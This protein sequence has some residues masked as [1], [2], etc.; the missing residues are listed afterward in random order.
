MRKPLIV[1]I[2]PGTTAAYCALDAKGDIVALDSGKQLNPSSIIF[3]LNQLGRVIVI[4]TDKRKTPFSVEKISI[5]LGAR[6][7]SP[8]E[9]ISVRDKF[10][11]SE[12]S[13]LRNNHELDA[14]ASARYAF[15]KIEPLLTKIKT[16]LKEEGK[17][18]LFEKIAPLVVIRGINIKTAISLIE[19]KEESIE[20]KPSA[21]YQKPET[22]PR[23]F[24][25]IINSLRKENY[26]LKKQNLR[27]LRVIE[28]KRDEKKLLL[29]KLRVFDINV[30]TQQILELQEK[31]IRKLNRLLKENEAYQKKLIGELI[32]LERIILKENSEFIIV[33]KFAS[34]EGFYQ[35]ERELELKKGDV[36]FIDSFKGMDKNKIDSLKKKVN[37]MTHKAVLPEILK[38]EN[39]IFIN[40]PPLEHE[41]ADFAVIRKGYLEEKIKNYNLL[42]KLV[43]EYR[44]ERVE[45]A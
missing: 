32:N 24:E 37:I 26:W 41:T 14:L 33:K 38:R 16:T 39:F 19:Y 5:K 28:K 21:V 44:E 7:I 43:R 3:S 45:N 40:N 11:L 2:D 12:N 23:L 20:T 34:F 30:K 29:K 9:D 8:E 4:G 10:R 42:Q 17:N 1:G 31:R 22:K 25:E 18:D 35:K 15:K 6:I 27:F 13:E 36:I